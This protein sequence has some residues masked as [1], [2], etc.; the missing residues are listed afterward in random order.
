MNYK[1]LFSIVVATIYICSISSYASVN[2]NGNIIENISGMTKNNILNN[3]SLSNEHMNL[4]SETN[5]SNSEVIL[6]HNNILKLLNNGYSKLPVQHNLN[7]EYSKLYVPQND[8]D[9]INIINIA[10]ENSNEDNSNGITSSIGKHTINTN[11]IKKESKSICKAFTSTICNVI[12]LP[13]SICSYIFYGIVNSATSIIPESSIH[14]VTMD[15]RDTSKEAATIS[16][17]NSMTSLVK[18]ITLSCGKLANIGTN[19]IGGAK[20][21]VVRKIWG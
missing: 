6:H 9:I 11:I 20:S 5:K 18:C 8:N 19:A 15:L 2:D 4:L 7:N 16:L 1:I 13:V 21:Y 17:N 12:T 10:N 14:K 3:S